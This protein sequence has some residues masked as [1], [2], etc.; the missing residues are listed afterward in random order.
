VRF[1]FDSEGMDSVLLQFSSARFADIAE[2]FLGR[3]GSPTLRNHTP[4]Q[5]SF[6]ARLMNE[7]LSWIGSKVIIGLYKYG[8][9][10]TES[11]ALLETMQRYQRDTVRKQQ[12]KDKAK[13]DLGP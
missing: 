4:L 10:S 9:K 5:N 13:Q 1:D 6:G 3:Y 12:N 11:G 2:A 8:E 7:Q